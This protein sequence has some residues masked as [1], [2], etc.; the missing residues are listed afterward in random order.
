MHVYIYL[1]AVSYVAYIKY[2]VNYI[3]PKLN[4]CLESL[5]VQ[6]VNMHYDIYNFIFMKWKFM[7]LCLNSQNFFAK[8]SVISEND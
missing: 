5:H 3:Q 8:G 1:Q 2:M 7:C 6:E 4:V